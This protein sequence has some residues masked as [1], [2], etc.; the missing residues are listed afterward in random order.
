MNTHILLTLSKTITFVAIPSAGLINNTSLYA[1]LYYLA[2]PRHTFVVENVEMRL[3]K[4][5]GDFVFH[6]LNAGFVANDFIAFFQR[7][8]TAVI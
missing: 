2:F 3:F 1:Q 5:G 8:D 6:H 7:T 4:W